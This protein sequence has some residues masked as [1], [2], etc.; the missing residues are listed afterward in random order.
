MADETQPG[1]GHALSE[2]QYA[3]IQ[4]S[5]DLMQ[6]ELEALRARGDTIGTQ[7]SL[8]EE[9]LEGSDDDHEPTEPA[10][11]APTEPVEPAPEPEPVEPAPEPPS[12]PEEPVEPP[13]PDPEPQPSEIDA[14]RAEIAGRVR[15]DSLVDGVDPRNG[16]GFL[17]GTMA[18]MTGEA[19]S[20]F[21]ARMGFK[22]RLT[23]GR[24]F[25]VEAAKWRAQTME[26]L[27]GG[28]VS[29]GV[30]Y[31]Q[32]KSAANLHFVPATKPWISKLAG[33]TDKD[34]VWYGIP[35]APLNS[36]PKII[37]EIIAG[38]HDEIIKM[39]G[40]RV[41][42][43]IDE[44]GQDHRRLI[45]R[46]AYEMTQNTACSF[47]L[48]GKGGVGF[49]SLPW[50]SRK[51]AFKKWRL[52]NSQFSRMFRKGYGYKVLIAV[53]PAYQSTTIPKSFG[54]VDYEE[55]LW[56]EVDICCGSYHPIA[57][58]I[59]TEAAARALSTDTTPS[60]FFGPAKI[61][62]AARRTGRFWAFLEHSVSTGV[63]S[64]ISGDLKW[65]RAAYEQFAIECNGNADI[66]AFT[67]LLST[68]ML[69]EAWPGEKSKP[70]VKATADNQA[71][72]KALV[73]QHASSG[74]GGFGSKLR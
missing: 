7:L 53:S 18:Y 38:K 46:Q 60:V 51:E 1:Q 30:G 50:K 32:E 24:A 52:V 63:G 66:G 31:V 61:I 9:L 43:Q 57:E 42:R 48:N 34:Y 55:F 28:P 59:K 19:L 5:I 12:T 49:F 27:A 33:I 29:K 25:I 14:R 70:P 65:A 2:E 35:F 20:Q 41:R 73:R 40:A 62:A 45:I 69:S 36:D 22:P 17:I 11:E 39:W 16:R 6:Q 4:A 37:D 67:G 26:D 64:W 44:A 8:L 58:R 56:D 68:P 13:A 71:G 21:E 54:N 3:E 23:G 15:L 74:D 47:T 10:P 72:W